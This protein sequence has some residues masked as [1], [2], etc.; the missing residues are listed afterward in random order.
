M[1]R[2]LTGSDLTFAPIL[3]GLVLSAAL[4]LSVQAGTITTLVDLNSGTAPAPTGTNSSDDFL[5]SD[6][7]TP[8]SVSAATN[9]GFVGTT[10]NWSGAALS[11]ASATTLGVST[12][13]SLTG[14]NSDVIGQIN[15]FA[16]AS[17][18]EFFI[19]DP[20]SLAT[21]FLSPVFG[22]TGTLSA[23]P[24]VP[25]QLTMNSVFFSTTAGTQI[26]PLFAANAP[27]DGSTLSINQMVAPIAYA[28]TST[29]VISMKVTLSANIENFALGGLSAGDYSA[30]IDFDDTSTF[31]GFAVYE[32][33]AMTMAVTSGISITTEDGVAISIID[34]AGV[35]GNVP[36]PFTLTL[37]V[38]GVLAHFTRRKRIA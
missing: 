7:S 16:S 32:D 26:D 14:F 11:A 24:G 13:L 35:P 19:F 23:S 2:L 20:G 9:T 38:A 17:Y 4:P 28:A 15:Q 31:M 1:A 5:L 33:A 12:S 8:I 29:D 25:A 6:T 22:L 36:E 37:L 21:F 10:T 34:P 30:L 3:L 27:G 18:N